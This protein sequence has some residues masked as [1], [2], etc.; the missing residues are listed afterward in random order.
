MKHQNLRYRNI[1]IINGEEKELKDFTPEERRIMSEE[2]NRRAAAA[3]NYKEV[4]KPA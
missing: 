3:V 4:T 1:V 2:W